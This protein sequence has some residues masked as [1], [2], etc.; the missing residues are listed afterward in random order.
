MLR[1]KIGTLILFFLSLLVFQPAGIWGSLISLIFLC[2][3]IFVLV[4]E[5]LDAE[6]APAPEAEPDTKEA[7]KPQQQPVPNTLNVKTTPIDVTPAPSK[8]TQIENVLVEKIAFKRTS[9]EKSLL[10]AIKEGNIIA[11]RHLVADGVNVNT[12]NTKGITA[13]MFAVRFNQLEMVR[14]LIENN[15]DVLTQSE[16]GSTALSIAK[17]N[18]NQEIIE[19]LLAAGAME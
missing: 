12:V 1:F 7:A 14:I 8:A 6:K 3:F 13:L 11:V 2:G 5:T 9:E 16:T 15:A 18:N 4:K 10:N 17:E 19:Y